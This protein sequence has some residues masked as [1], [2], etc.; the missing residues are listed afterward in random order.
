MQCLRGLILWLQLGLG[1]RWLMVAGLP[2]PRMD[3]S[4]LNMGKVTLMFEYPLVI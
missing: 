2:A 4:M 3:C 1:H